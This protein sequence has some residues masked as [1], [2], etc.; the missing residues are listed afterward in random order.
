MIQTLEA[1]VDKTGK[2]RL[3]GGDSFGEKSSGVG[4]DLDEELKED[5]SSKKENRRAVFSKM[6]GVEMFRGVENVSDWQKTE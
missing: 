5:E 2:I 4:D 3:S 1:I 6:R